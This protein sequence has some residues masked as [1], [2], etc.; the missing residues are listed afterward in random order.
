[1]NNRAV[2][3]QSAGDFARAEALFTRSPSRARVCR[4]GR[5]PGRSS[6]AAGGHPRCAQRVPARAGAHAARSLD[7]RQSRGA[8]FRT[9]PGSRGEGGA[10]ARRSDP[11]D[12]V[13][14]PGARRPRGRRR[15]RRRRD[16]LL[17]PGG[18]ARPEAT[19]PSRLD[20][21]PR[22][23][24]R[25]P[26][27][28]PPRGRARRQ[29]RPGEPGG[30]RS[31]RNSAT[32]RPLALDVRPESFPGETLGGWA[33]SQIEYRTRWKP[34][35]GSPGRFAVDRNMTPF[36]GVGQGDDVFLT[37]VMAR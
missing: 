35:Q 31:S 26:G 36:S 9:G 28:G 10:Q 33:P 30:R 3:A 23:C 22:A 14:D 32:S 18:A 37:S 4:R 2:V 27:R 29:A 25:T 19:R 11:R 15:P 5:K 21:S 13:H 12:A 20:G 7:P 24:R 6:K 1:M 16:A 8:L 17:P 34:A